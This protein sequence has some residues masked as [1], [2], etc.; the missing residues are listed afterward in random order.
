[1]R[2]IYRNGVKGKRSEDKMKFH[3]IKLKSLTNSFRTPY[4]YRSSLPKKK[5]EKLFFFK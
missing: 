4:L 3:L 5:N 2:G 1:M